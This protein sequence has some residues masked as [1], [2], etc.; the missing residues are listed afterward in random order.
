M[1]MVSVCPSLAKRQR[2]NCSSLNKLIYGRSEENHIIAE[3]DYLRMN[4]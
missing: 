3:E 1:N 4:H 2:V